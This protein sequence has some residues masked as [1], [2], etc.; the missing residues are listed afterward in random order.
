[1]A[2]NTNDSMLSITSRHLDHGLRKLHKDILISC[3]ENSS[4]GISVGGN[5][6]ENIKFGQAGLAYIKEVRRP[7]SPS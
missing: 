2:M 5:L 1:M 6:I 7:I 3:S 4:I